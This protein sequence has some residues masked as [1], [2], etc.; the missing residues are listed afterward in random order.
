M[1]EE[2]AR[3]PYCGT[4]RGGTTT[5]LDALYR[6]VARFTELARRPQ[7]PQPPNEEHE[8]ALKEASAR[9]AE[10]LREIRLLQETVARLRGGIVMLRIP[11]I[12]YVHPTMN[13]HYHTKGAGVA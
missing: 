12:V 3:C 1:S 6:E 4:I 5:A 10:L 11:D 9:E 7:P 2:I 8:R 13:R